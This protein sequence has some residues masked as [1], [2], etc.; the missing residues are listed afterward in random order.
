MQCSPWKTA[1]SRRVPFRPWWPSGSSGS[2]PL[3]SPTTKSANP[4]QSQQFQ[5]HLPDPVRFPYGTVPAVPSPSHCGS[6]LFDRRVV[7]QPQPDVQGPEE[8]IPFVSTLYWSSVTIPRAAAR[9]APSGCRRARTAGCDP[10]W[11]SC[12]Y[13]ATNSTSTTPPRP[14]FRF[15]GSHVPGPAPGSIRMPQTVDL[16]RRVRRQRPDRR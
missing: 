3:I 2:P 16:L 13:C 14:T 15:T 5:V 7:R 10:P 12:R 6:K 1:G 4:R 9:R 11:R 8:A